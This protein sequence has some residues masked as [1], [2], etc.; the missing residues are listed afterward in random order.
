MF[1]T[2]HLNPIEWASAIILAVGGLNWL[3]VGLFEF[4]LVAEIFGET[5]GTTNGVTRAVY[6]LVGIAAIYTIMGLLRMEAMT[7]R[8]ERDEARLD[9]RGTR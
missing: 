1:S 9:A 8:H 4:D 6:I 3:L 2:Q 7:M 5:F